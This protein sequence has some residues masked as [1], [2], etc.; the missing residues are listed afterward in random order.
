MLHSS[1]KGQSNQPGFSRRIGNR[2]TFALEFEIQA[3]APRLWN[4]SWGSLWLWVG[5]HLVGRPYETEMVQIGLDS[6]N[7]TAGENRASASRI[8]SACSPSEALQAVMWARYGGQDSV[9]VKASAVDD[10]ALFPLEVLPRRTG[11]FFD[12]WEAILVDE[13][14]IERFVYRRGDLPPSHPNHH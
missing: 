13:G 11:L 12:G 6:L 5:G 9:H 8:L 7:E 3:D 1:N 2:W 14:P 4:E 10:E